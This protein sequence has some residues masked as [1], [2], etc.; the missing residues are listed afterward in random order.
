MSLQAT[1]A[2]TI[3]QPGNLIFNEGSTGHSI[4][5]HPSSEIPDHYTI[6]IGPMYWSPTPHSWNGQAINYNVDGLP[7]GTTGYICTVY[8]TQG[9]SASSQVYVT[10]LSP[11]SV[12][13]SPSS[14][15]FYVGGAQVFFS[16]VNSNTSRVSY[17]WYL[18]GAA[19][20]GA[21]GATWMFTPSSAG[22]YTVYL[23]IHDAEGAVATS[24]TASVTVNETP[25]VSISP[26]SVV[27]NLGMSQL[28]SSSVS[29]GVVPSYYQWFLN[30]VAVS[31]AN[32]ASWTFTP[33]SVGTYTVHLLVIYS[34]F[35]GAGYSNSATVTV[36]VPPPPPLPLFAVIFPS[37]ATLEVG[38]SWTFASVVGGGAS[39]Y[40]YQWYLNGVA[41]PGATHV[42]WMFA[43][44]SAGSYTVYLKVTDALGTVA[45]TNTAAVT[46]NVTP[47]VSVSPSSVTLDVGMS[48]LFAS[49]VSG[50][51]S[52]L[53]YQWYLDGAAVSGAT[54][55]TWMFAPSSAGSY[56]VYLIMTDSLGMQG[57]SNTVT[58]T[59]NP[60]DT[61]PPQTSINLVGTQGLAGWYKSAVTATLLATDPSPGSGV[62]TTQY[63]FDGS[64]WI[65][66][67]SPLTITNEGLTTIHYRSTDLAGN[68]EDQKTLDIWIDTT[69]PTTT[70]KLS[71]TLG[72]GGWYLSNLSVSLTAT[73][74]ASGVAM[75]AYRVNGGPWTTYTQQ[76]TLVAEGTYRIEYN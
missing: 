28:F 58:V 61:T 55:D 1:A 47:S 4:T 65:T 75:T 63:S 22:S 74:Y 19:V 70:A 32:G 73:D 17:Q 31:G 35:G 68:I 36:N 49:T 26:S 25:S 27:L 54:G 18:D 9:R 38:T 14:A 57:S 11:L 40:S 3:D 76:F 2:P 42:S 67:T 5:W 48:Q 46:V 39:P 21:T 43:P 12:S 69:P 30:D 15:T 44:S 45:T 66:Y 71:G 60:L 56:T 8:D 64:N 24:G 29:G 37:S 23:K 59:V 13:I 62:A 33:S 6:S 16:S 7:W 53:S 20:S 41:V 50:G 51:T 72:L 52:P 10:V 34:I